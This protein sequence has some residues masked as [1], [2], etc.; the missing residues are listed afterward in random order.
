M[1]CNY[2]K[3]IKVIPDIFYR[4]GRCPTCNGDGTIKEK[5]FWKFY[6]SKRCPQCLGRR[7]VVIGPSGIKILSDVKSIN[8]SGIKW[9]LD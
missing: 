1:W 8:Q 6:S 4:Y 7:Q 3:G 9:K 2:D 5:I